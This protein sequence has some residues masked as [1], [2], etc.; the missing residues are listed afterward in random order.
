ME[1]KLLFAIGVTLGS[2]VLS[3]SFTSF[4]SFR[5]FLHSVLLEDFL[6]LIMLILIYFL[7]ERSQMVLDYGAIAITLVVGIHFGFFLKRAEHDSVDMHFFKYFQIQVVNLMTLQVDFITSTVIPSAMYAVFAIAHLIME[8][9]LD[10]EKT[11]VSSLVA[12]VVVNAVFLF[13]EWKNYSERVLNYLN[14]HDEIKQVKSVTNLIKKDHAG[15]II[16]SPTTKEVKF[17]N[18]S[19]TKLFQ[20]KDFN[21]MLDHPIV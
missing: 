2:L 4:V 13:Y 12:F 14:R 15:V 1:S 3:I 18:R 8:T 11:L 17:Q 10:L 21:N 7:H 9:Q 5:D 16:F 19:V 20:V 6:L